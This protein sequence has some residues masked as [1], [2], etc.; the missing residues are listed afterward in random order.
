MSVSW[1]IQ[2]NNYMNK[3]GNITLNKWTFRFGLT[4]IVFPWTPRQSIVFY[5][6][7]F[8][9]TSFPDEGCEVSKENYKGFWIKKDF[10]GFEIS[11]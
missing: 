11:L 8:K 4:P 10:N 9:L 6:G 2:H 3:R 5:F 7:I 1:H